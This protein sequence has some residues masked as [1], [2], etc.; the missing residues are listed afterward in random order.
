MPRKDSFLFMSNLKSS[1]HS[2]DESFCHLLLGQSY[3]GLESLVTAPLFSGSSWRTLVSQAVHKRLIPVMQSK[4]VAIFIGFG[5]ITSGFTGHERKSNHFT[6]AR[7]SAP[8]ATLCYPAFPSTSPTNLA[9]Q[10]GFRET[11]AKPTF[12]QFVQAASLR[13]GCPAHR[14]PPM[15]QIERSCPQASHLYTQHFDSDCILANQ[16]VGKIVLASD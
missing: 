9:S 2:L 12:L 4:A 16:S 6:P 3:V 5:W 15:S 14:M 10:H 11:L 8:C 7:M 13:A 1:N